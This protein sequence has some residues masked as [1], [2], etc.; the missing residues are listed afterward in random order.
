MK[1][2]INY[3]RIKSAME[4]IASNFNRQ[5]NIE[6]I[7]K[8][9]H[10]SEFHFQRLF[11]DWAGV[12]PKKFLQYITLNELKKHISA[13]KNIEALSELAGFSSPSRVY[14]LFVNIE[15]VTPN[16]YKTQGAGISIEYGIHNSPFG[17]CLI[18]NTSRGICALEFIDDNATMVIQQFM[19]KWQ[20]ASVHH[21]QQST[22]GLVNAVFNKT[23]GPLKA[24]LY[25]TG[26][27]IKVWEAL[28]KIPF[29]QLATYA[30]IAEQI[31]SPKAG[32][33]VGSAIGKNNIAY[34]IPCHRVIRSLGGL[35]G[36]KWNEGRKLSMIGWEAARTR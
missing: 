23:K 24:L 35:G 14:D 16:E 34:L 11:K 12:S 8:H 30:A 1:E 33:A 9:V 20:N 21:N 19:Q 2:N 6:D 7:A 32:R 31:K 4:F 10:L 22:S 26:F 29:G 18:A 27:Q 28:L 36:Y 13:A 3:C 25:G 17:L 15:A 5:P